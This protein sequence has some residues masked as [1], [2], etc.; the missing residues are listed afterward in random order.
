MVSYGVTV[1]DKN[2]ITTT[3]LTA[4]LLHS[5]SIFL[6]WLKVQECDMEMQVYR[7]LDRQ[8]DKL[9]S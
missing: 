7:Q 6:Y 9:V 3:I 1:H 5:C 8:L 4:N 2:I